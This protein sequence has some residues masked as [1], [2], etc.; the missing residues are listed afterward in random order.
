MRIRVTQLWLEGVAIDSRELMLADRA[1]MGTLRIDTKDGERLASLTD[2]P[3]YPAKPR[4]L[5]PKLWSPAIVKLDGKVFRLRGV[6]KVGGRLFHQ[7]WDCYL[8]NR[9]D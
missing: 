7:E 6:Q 1:V 2:A 3:L 9:Q 4:D 5:V 8:L